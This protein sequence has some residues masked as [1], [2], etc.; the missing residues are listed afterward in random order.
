MDKNYIKSKLKHKFITHYRN[1]GLD[2]P[3]YDLDYLVKEVESLGDYK[4]IWK[5]DIPVKI[6]VLD[7]PHK[8][9][10]IGGKYYIYD[11]KGNFNQQLY[12]SEFISFDLREMREYKLKKI[13]KEK[14]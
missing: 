10:V 11:G 1:A 5:K 2:C 3:D 13:L 8:V 14:T 12:S 9:D 4:I 6:V 7:F